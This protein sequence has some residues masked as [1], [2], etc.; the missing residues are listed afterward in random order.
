[1]G[2]RD[3]KNGLKFNQNRNILV[4]FK[5]AIEGMLYCVRHEANF[6]VHLSIM[7]AMIGMA[8][9]FQVTTVEWCVLMLT[10]GMVLVLELMNTA[11]EATVDLVVGERHHPLAKVAKDTAAGAV[12][13]MAAF[14]VVV[15]LLIFVPRILGLWQ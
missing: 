4:A 9:Y 10:S 8:F 14:A 6:K 13:L 12:L 2:L 15:G 1:M 5:V 7:L 3:S 11:V